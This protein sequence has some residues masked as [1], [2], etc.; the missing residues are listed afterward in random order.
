MAEGKYMSGIK[1]LRRLYSQKL[2]AVISQI[3]KTADDFITI[4]NTYSGITVSLKV[5]TGKSAA[6]LSA[7][8]ESLGLNVIESPAVKT[9]DLKTKDMIFY[10]NQI[11]LTEISD[12]VKHLINLWRK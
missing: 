6:I 3:K 9:D 11:P 4:H 2:N 8:A 12:N 1:K 5:N 10:Y 7:E